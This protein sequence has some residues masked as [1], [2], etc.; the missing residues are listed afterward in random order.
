MTEKSPSRSLAFRILKAIIVYGYLAWVALCRILRAPMLSMFGLVMM[1]EVFGGVL[2]GV[3]VATPLT[4]FKDGF[5]ALCFGLL[6]IPCLWLSIWGTDELKR[7]LKAPESIG[8]MDRVI[9]AVFAMVALYEVVAAQQLIRA[10]SGPFETVIAQ[11]EPGIETLSALRFTLT[12]WTI[13]MAYKFK[14]FWDVAVEAFGRTR[15]SSAA[16]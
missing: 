2:L 5:F 8:W 1:R 9:L 12:A 13:L 6:V 10:L 3:K 7:D 15:G 11:G 4:H 14:V 16:P